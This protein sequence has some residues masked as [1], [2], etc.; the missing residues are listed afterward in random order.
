MI[1]AGA[2]IETHEVTEVRYKTR[3]K[4][5]GPNMLL[6]EYDCGPIHKFTKYLCFDHTP[7][8]SGMA[9]KWWKENAVT[10][11]FIPGDVVTAFNHVAN[12]KKPIKLVVRTDQKHVQ[13]LEWIYA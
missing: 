8:V 4:K 9:K 13:I 1:E 6:I 5:N 11:D 7:Q 2:E 3:R 10:T 12:L